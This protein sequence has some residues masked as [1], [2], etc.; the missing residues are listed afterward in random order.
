MQ[1]MVQHV[2]YDL[3]TLVLFLM[4]QFLIGYPIWDPISRRRIGV[5][6]IGHLIEAMCREE[7]RYCYSLVVSMRA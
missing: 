2:N 3:R 5:S 4:A 7:K 6:D 1:F